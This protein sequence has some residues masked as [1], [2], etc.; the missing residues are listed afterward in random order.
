MA[1]SSAAPVATTTPIAP[2]KVKKIAC[3]GAGE[4]QSPLRADRLSSD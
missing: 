2:I 3:I 4:L 1:G